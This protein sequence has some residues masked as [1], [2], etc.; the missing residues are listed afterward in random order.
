M[1]GRTATS[2]DVAESVH[3]LPDLGHPTIR[4][5]VQFRQQAIALSLDVAPQSTFRV[6][7]QAD[8]GSGAFESDSAF[9]MVGIGLAESH[10]GLGEQS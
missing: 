2:T 4:L 10:K 1:G 7:Q 8:E 3:F 5:I 6:R 9:R